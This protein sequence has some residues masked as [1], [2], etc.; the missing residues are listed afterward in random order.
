MPVAQLTEDSTRV[1]KRALLTQCDAASA[2]LTEAMARG[3]GYRTQAALRA[4]LKQSAEARY[5]LFD[6][7]A[8]RRRLDELGGS[9]SVSEIALPPLE[10]A[11]RYVEGLF[12]NPDIDILELRPMTVRFR[13]SGIDIE[14]R[15]DLED[16]GGGNVRFH[17]SH[18]IHTPV[19]IGPYH[20]GR[21]WDDDPAYAMHR[22]IESL[23]SYYQQALRAGHKPSPQWLV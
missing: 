8:F 22:A 15:I 4:D 20:P 1:M 6:E 21:D 14:V 5:V 19:Q 23:A 11:A 7:A 13:L 2:Q 12:N 16:V 17:R 3:L 10:H 18:A 9:V